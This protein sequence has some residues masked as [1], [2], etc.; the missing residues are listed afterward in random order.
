MGRM[1]SPLPSGRQGLATLRIMASAFVLTVPLLGVVVGV[2]LPP[3]QLL[4][5]PPLNDLAVPIAVSVLAFALM[6]AFGHRVS[7]LPPSTGSDDAARF[8]MTQFQTTL[9]VRLAI[10]E[11]PVLISL[12]MVFAT[13]DASLV[14]YAIGAVASLLLHALYAFPSRASIARV[15]ERLDRD[16]GQS[17][18]SQSL[19]A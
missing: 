19:D 9:F 5:V 17:H 13:E 3:D 16:G 18:L 14:T 11:I 1:S 12:V 4:A 7:A 8:G 15:E 6:L 10:A 2:A